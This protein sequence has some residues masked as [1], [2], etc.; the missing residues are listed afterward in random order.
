MNRF[1]TTPDRYTV[2]AW[3]VLLACL[4]RPF[5][6]VLLCAQTVIPPSSWTE[7]FVIEID[8]E[9]KVIRLSGDFD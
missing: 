9:H 3:K 7:C 8:D 5:Y 4:K 6:D 1:N 2:P